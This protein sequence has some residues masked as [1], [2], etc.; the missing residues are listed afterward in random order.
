MKNLNYASQSN[1][2][3]SVSKTI[4]IFGMEKNVDSGKLVLE[5]TTKTRTYN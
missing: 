4:Q 3:S 2:P 1:N 5:D